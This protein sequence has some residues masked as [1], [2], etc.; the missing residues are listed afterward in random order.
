VDLRLYISRFV[1]CWKFG[2]AVLEQCPCCRLK[3]NWCTM[4]HGPINV[5]EEFIY[6]I[7]LLF[8][9][10]MGILKMEVV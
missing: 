6:R 3:Y 1:V 10:Y 9:D 5:S 2:A 7:S 4:M 8:I